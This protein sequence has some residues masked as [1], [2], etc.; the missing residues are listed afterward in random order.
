MADAERQ[1]DLDDALQVLFE[2]G[3]RIDTV[4]FFEHFDAIKEILVKSG[5]YVDPDDEEDDNG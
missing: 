2:A 4:E 1:K 3:L 5:E